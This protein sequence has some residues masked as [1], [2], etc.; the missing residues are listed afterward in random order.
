MLEILLVTMGCFIAAFINAAFATG[1]VYIMLAFISLVLPITVA[2]PLLPAFAMPSLFARICMF[3]Q[4]IRWEIVKPFVVGSAFGVSFGSFIFINLSDR[5]ISIFIALI[6]LFITWWPKASIKMPRSNLFLFV[7]VSHSFLG[8]LFG[9]GGILQSSIFRT[10][11]IKA[12]VTGTL[13]A[14]LLSMGLFKVSSY[15]INGFSYSFYTYHLI[16]AAIAGFAGAWIGKRVSLSI[17]ND[18]FRKVF[19]IIVTLVAFQLLVKGIFFSL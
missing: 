5:L 1:G 19:K 10:S 7:G 12:Q 3:W 17:T 14:C 6:I 11:L 16:F 18:A 9:I 13:A 2:I 15:V 8:T 4:H